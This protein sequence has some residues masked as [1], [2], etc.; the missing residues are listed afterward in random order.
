M[1]RRAMWVCLS[2]HGAGDVCLRQVSFRRRVGLWWQQQSATLRLRW[3]W[4]FRWA[5]PRQSAR[6]C[7]WWWKCFRRWQ[8]LW[9]WTQGEVAEVVAAEVEVVAGLHLEAGRAL[10]VEEARAV[11]RGGQKGNAFQNQGHGGSSAFG[12]SNHLSVVA[13]VN[14]SDRAGFHPNRV[15]SSRSRTAAWTSIWTR[16]AE[17]DAVVAR[18]V[19]KAARAVVARVSKYAALASDATVPTANSS[20][21]SARRSKHKAVPLE[22]LPASVGQRQAEVPSAEGTLLAAVAATPSVAAKELQGSNLLRSAGAT[23]LSEAVATPSAVV[24]VVA[25][26][27]V[28]AAAPSVAVAVPSVV[29]AVVPSAAAAVPSAAAAVPSAAA[30]VP[31]AAAAGA[32]PSVAAAVPSAAAAARQVT[33]QAKGVAKAKGVVREEDEEPLVDRAQ[34]VLHREPADGQQELNSIQQSHRRQQR[35]PCSSRPSPSR[36]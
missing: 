16:A 22:L 15:G 24:V 35:L 21:R 9:W 5:E 31:S 36:W 28:A 13:A 19:E 11:V 30:A 27:A 23:A 8:C 29:A 33:A 20:I 17:E 25:P 14:H 3:R 2:E 10:S 26:S 34:V 18:A 6:Q 7:L 12:G 4:G 1:K 32:V